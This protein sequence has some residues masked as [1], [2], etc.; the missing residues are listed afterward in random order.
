MSLLRGAYFFM[1]TK[2][3]DLYFLDFYKQGNWQGD[4]DIYLIPNNLIYNHPVN[5]KE[6]F[7]DYQKQGRRPRFSIYKDIILEHEISPL[8]SYS[9][10]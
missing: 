2:I 3:I 5:K 7:L 1:V 4:F 6:T 10:T 9:L 8:K